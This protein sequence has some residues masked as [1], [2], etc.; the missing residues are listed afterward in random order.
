[1]K[2]SLVKTIT[3]LL[4]VLLFL[5]ASSSCKQNPSS[6][7]PGDS[8][9]GEHGEE[10]AESSK[11]DN[12]S[13]E[14]EG[15][16]FD[17]LSADLT[18]YVTVGSYRD[19]TV[20]IDSITITSSQIYSSINQLV[21]QKEGYTKIVDREAQEGDTCI[22][23]FVGK[24]NGVAFDKGSATNQSITLGENSGYIAGFA[25][26][27]IGHLPGT[28]FSINVTFPENY[29][30]EELNGKE[31]VFD[32][33]LHYIIDYTLTEDILLRISEGNAT[34]E[35]EL[36]YWVGETLYDS[37][38]R[39][40][41]F[42]AVWEEIFNDSTVIK[43]PE[44][45]T[46]YYFKKLVQQC[47]NSASQYGITYETYLAYNGITEDTF[48]T[49][50]A[51]YTRSD[52]IAYQIAKVENLLPT[53]AE[54]RVSLEK[55]AADNYEDLKAYLIHYN[56]ADSSFSLEDAV[57]YFDEYY[58]DSIKSEILKNHLTDYLLAN[59]TIQVREDDS[60]ES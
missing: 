14:D 25:E 3:A 60:A 49:Y 57:E 23:D 52:L 1:M 8:S 16:L 40:N 4:L 24:L 9:S 10:T 29:G 39:S 46:D 41:A 34:T 31:A 26:G 36:Y 51:S 12:S 32:I 45:S 17:Y 20:E 35:S 18:E 55:Y 42:N 6:G 53:D 38:Y 21:Q 56:V 59:N 19:R 15:H 47:K 11:E 50:A 30:K 22:I 54:Y 2:K 43:L 27:I 37:T 5:L 13:E 48:K 28:S 7:T 33:T 58:S 44:E